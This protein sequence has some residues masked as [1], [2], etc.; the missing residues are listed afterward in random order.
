[1]CIRD[2]IMGKN[3]NWDEKTKTITIS[4]DRDEYK[5][6]TKP[7]RESREDIDLSLIHI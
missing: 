6:T 7:A 5:N 4:G 3:V 2:R 1:M